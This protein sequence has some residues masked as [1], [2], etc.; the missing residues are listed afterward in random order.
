M[1]SSRRK[2]VVA[3]ALVV[4]LVAA[5]YA[6]ARP[7]EVAMPAPH[8][9]APLPTNSAEAARAV[10][11]TNS[12]Q[13]Q[14]LVLRPRTDDENAGLLTAFSI[15]PAPS[16][17]APSPVQVASVNA[18]PAAVAPP[19]PPPFPFQVVGR[20]VDG[21]DQRVFL[22]FNGQNLVARPGDSI[23]ADYTVSAIDADQ[24]TVHYM[25]L[26]VSQT[27]ALPAPR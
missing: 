25:P 11:T 7:D 5:Y 8:A 12:G 6:P 21:S 13:A 15:P 2:A 24:L 22:I 1:K 19:A 14:A 3:A 9:N 20:F 17:M 26:D 16:V 4:T 10:P 18:A 23:G 27:V